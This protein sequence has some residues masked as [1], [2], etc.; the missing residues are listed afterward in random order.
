[1]R[2]TIFKGPDLFCKLFR[3]PFIVTILLCYVVVFGSFYAGI[4][5]RRF[6]FVFLVPKV[7]NPFVIEAV[8]NF[9]GVIG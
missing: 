8:N 2:R 1:L 4:P 5:R 7:S 9:L 6:A 3:K